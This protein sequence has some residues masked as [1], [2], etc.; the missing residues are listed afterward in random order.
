MNDIPTVH[1]CTLTVVVPALNEEGNLD[2][3]LKGLLD[4]LARLQI[5]A[6]VIVVNDGSTDGT[7]RIAERCAGRERRVRVIHHP[8]PRGVGASFMECAGS[9]RGSFITWFPGD[10][11][12]DPAE[13]LKYV[14][15]MKKIDIVVPFVVNQKCRRWT[16]RVISSLFCN[17]FNRSFG[18]AFKYMN[19]NIIFKTDLLRGLHIRNS[20]FLCWAEMLLKLTRAGASYAEVPVRIPEKGRSAGSSKAFSL[21]SISDVLTGYARLFWDIHCGPS[22]AGVRAA[23]KEAADDGV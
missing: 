15:L 12:N 6:E 23:R 17:I 10:G 4:E 18:T 16:R 19:G 13:L 2:A 8:R 21:R 5:N 22:D 20:G 3:T 14:E 9:A 1:P 7:G 11:E